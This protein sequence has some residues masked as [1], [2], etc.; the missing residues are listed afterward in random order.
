ML[1]IVNYSIRGASTKAPLE[2]E[3]LDI[4]RDDVE[5]FFQEVAGYVETGINL[6]CFDE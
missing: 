5:K 2:D 1:T 4:S 3:G 6:G